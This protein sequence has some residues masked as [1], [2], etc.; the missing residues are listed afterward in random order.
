MRQ[1]G[2]L[3]VVTNIELV[4]FSA[5]ISP[6]FLFS[7]ALLSLV[8]MRSLGRA[9]LLALG[10]LSGFWSFWL[11]FNA[12]PL[13]ISEATLNLLGDIF[14]LV[15]TYPHH[16]QD[17]PADLAR[18]SLMPMPAVQKIA[19]PPL[20]NASVKI[21]N[22]TAWPGFAETYV[23]SLPGR[24]DRRIGMERIR[25]T[26]PWLNWTYVPATPADDPRIGRIYDRVREQRRA[27]ARG[28]VTVFA[29]PADLNAPAHPPHASSRPLGHS[30]ADLWEDAPAAALSSP[31]GADAPYMRGLEPRPELEPL[32][33]ASRD[34]VDGPPYAPALPPY[35]IL[36][37]AKLAC[38][39][40]HAQVLRAIAGRYAGD[41]ATISGDGEAERARGREVALILEDDVDMEQDLYERMED[42]WHTLPDEWD[43]LF[44]GASRAIE[45]GRRFIDGVNVQDIAGR[46]R[47]STP[48]W[49]A[50]A[51][52]RRHPEHGCTPRARRSART[53]TRSHAQGR[54][55]W[56]RT[57]GSRRSR[58][59]GR[60]TRRMR[61]WCWRDAC[62]ATRWCR[63]WWC[64][65]RSARATSMGVTLVWAVNG[66][67]RSSTVSSRGGRARGRGCRIWCADARTRCLGW[68]NGH[69]L[70]TEFNVRVPT[71]R[72]TAELK[73]QCITAC[74]TMLPGAFGEQWPYVACATRFQ[75]VASDMGAGAFPAIAVG[76]WALWSTRPGARRQEKTG[77]CTSG[78]LRR[79]V[80]NR[81]SSRNRI[82]NATTPRSD[83]EGQGPSG[84]AQGF[85]Y[86]KRGRAD[87]QTTIEE[88]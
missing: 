49:L 81:S 25:Q 35:M 85:A 62:R 32:T 3:D 2:S 65:A 28:N 27:L 54:V 7:H 52:R 82:D 84:E 56:S 14:S 1:L 70:A 79:V 18:Y 36:S 37:R 69:R 53:R 47:L 21:A 13:A 74:A 43:M 68:R 76:T 78:R 24:I 5:V 9:A 19:Q 51:R 8:D 16:S 22:Q 29:W 4:F 59:A 77:P 40:S 87:L 44:L 20:H 12:G 39:H 23:V 64:S 73:C 83:I 48:P 31:A 6:A 63:A 71:G 67:S 42:I 50:L 33:C 15:Q 30:G 75:Q 46:T 55:G 61:G 26:L 38:W 34:D 88:E 10:I 41:D 58:T 80:G 45:C 60:W 72:H 17:Q 11:Y 86:T 66:A 57:C